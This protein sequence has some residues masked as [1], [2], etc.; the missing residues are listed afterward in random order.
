M[1]SNS[2]A[3]SLFI[4]IMCANELLK[5]NLLCA[6]YIVSA[7]VYKF[8]PNTHQKYLGSVLQSLGGNGRRHIYYVLSKFKKFDSFSK[9][10]SSLKS[11][12]LKQA[13]LNSFHFHLQ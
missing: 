2:S 8:L 6:I 11:A 3:R 4:Q 7:Q 1:K 12:S 13:A 10:V 5:L 9:T